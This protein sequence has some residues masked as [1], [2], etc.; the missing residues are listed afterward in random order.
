MNSGIYLIDC[1]AN[2]A[3]YVGSSAALDGRWGRHRE[4]LIAG[5]HPN[6]H[7]QRTWNKYGA[8]SFSFSV[9]Q[10]VPVA[11]LLRVEQDYLDG[12]W[13]LPGR[14]NQARFASAPFRGRR[15]SESSRLA[16]S[17]AQL[18]RQ[19]SVATCIRKSL[20]QRGLSR[21]PAAR[22]A[23]QAANRRRRIAVERVDP[24]SGEVKEY[25]SLFEAQL[26]GFRPGVIS[27]LLQGVGQSH[28]GFWWKRS[29]EL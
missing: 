14:M 1:G 15:H 5:T 7:L 12:I 2:E 17:V 22:A 24:T 9:L 10:R 21:G 8:S 13:S 27:R 20:S 25:A 18:G 3:V 26:D 6:C 23:A 29:E 19:D 28:R 16:Q 11:E 4:Q